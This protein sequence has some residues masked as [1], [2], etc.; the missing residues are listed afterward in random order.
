MYLRKKWGGRE[1]KKG[2]R[3]TNERTTTQSKVNH[4]G[5]CLVTMCWESHEAP[6]TRDDRQCPWPSGTI[7]TTSERKDEGLVS[8][9]YHEI[10]K[11]KKGKQN[12]L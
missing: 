10:K 2:R 1:R 7:H 4:E 9:V 3:R 5:I 8:G 6:H 11:K 12:A